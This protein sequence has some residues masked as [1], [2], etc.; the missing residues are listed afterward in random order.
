[1]VLMVVVVVVDLE[2][3]IHAVATNELVVVEGKKHN[4]EKR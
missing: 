3:M 1:M 2:G 4:V